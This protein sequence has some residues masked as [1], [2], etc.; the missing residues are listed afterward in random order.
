MHALQMLMHANTQPL[1][2]QYFLAC[3]CH[4]RSHSV[5]LSELVEQHQQWQPCLQHLASMLA[6]CFG[7]KKDALMSHVLPQ[8]C[9]TP[10]TKQISLSVKVISSWCRVFTFSRFLVRHD[11]LQEQLFQQCLWSAWWW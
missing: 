8:V 7:C 6:V 10:N 5:H 9:G 11:V 1:Q 3:Y 2:Q 4:F